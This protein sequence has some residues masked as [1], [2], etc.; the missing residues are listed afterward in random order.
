MA[1]VGLALLLGACAGVPVADL[2][3]V[4]ARIVAASQWG[5]TPADPAKARTQVPTRIT[6]HHGGE[7]FSP[8]RDARG[9]L[10]RLQ[11]WSRSDR[12]WIDIPYHYV[13]DLEGNIYEG[14]DL[15]Y[16]GDTNTEYDPSGHALV[17]VLGNYEEIEPAPAQL[18]AVVDIMALIA[19]RHGIDP[20][21]IAAHKDFAASTLCPGRYLYP[22]VRDGYFR[23]AVRKRL[24]G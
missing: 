20:A 1:G 12:H 18:A 10:R 13:I 22:Y 7:A 14:R 2:P 16:A 23:D 8:G 4:Q 21:Q 3:A 19:A 11:A 6:L 9:Y 5:G 24:G 17:M 15:R